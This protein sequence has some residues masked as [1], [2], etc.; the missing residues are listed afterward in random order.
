[1]NYILMSIRARYA[2]LILSGRKTL[3][4]RKTAPQREQGKLRVHRFAL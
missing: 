4:I 2:A 3:E 1:M